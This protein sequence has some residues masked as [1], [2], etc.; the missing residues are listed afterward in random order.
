MSAD[1]E[2]IRREH[3]PVL[4]EP[5]H[6]S[7]SREIRE[8]EVCFRCE[9]DW[10]CD[11]IQL[12]EANAALAGRAERLEVAMRAVYEA[13]I[14]TPGNTAA[15]LVEPLWKALHAEVP[16]RAAGEWEEVDDAD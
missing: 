2:R 7:D 6:E 4:G 13:G 16:P 14:R 15:A 11:A 8:R 5:F 1:V 9:Q 3:V 10:P 12:I